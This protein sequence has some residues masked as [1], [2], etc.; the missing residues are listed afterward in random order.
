MSNINE[1]NSHFE[2]FNLLKYIKSMKRTI[3]SFLVLLMSVLITACG[4][5]TK[6]TG[7]W[8][9]KSAL[10]GKHYK[11]VFIYGLTEKET[12]KQT[13]ENAFA[14]EAAARNIAAFKS[15]EILDSMSDTSKSA[16]IEEVLQKIRS[17]GAETILTISLKQTQS[18]TRYVPGT[19]SYAP[20]STYG[21]YGNYYGYYGAAYQEVYQPGYYT[22]D[23][24]YF[25]ECNLYDAGSEELLYSAQSETTNPG[26]LD[27]F[28]KEYAA[29]IVWRMQQD[30]LIKK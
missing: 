9:N 20:I 27:A 5:T 24:S 23:K 30:G 7:S 11:S 19:A 8:M 2:W 1:W 18:S 17:T 14:K 12:V 10:E 21:Y 15:Y 25:I 4:P 26:R 29:V 3:N 22:T 28:A 16:T 6:I 13:I